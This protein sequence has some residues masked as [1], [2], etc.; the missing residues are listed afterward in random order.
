MNFIVD[1]SANLFGIAKFSDLKKIRDHLAQTKELMNNY[2]GGFHRY[3]QKV[4]FYQ[5]VQE[6]QVGNLKAW[7]YVNAEHIDII[8]NKLEEMQDSLSVELQLTRNMTREIKENINIENALMVWESYGI[9]TLEAAVQDGA[10]M[11]QALQQ[12]LAC[13]YK[14]TLYPQQCRRGYWEK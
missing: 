5:I 13:T 6:K 14:S 10:W 3:Q 11:F 12:L 8:H 4:H 1:I 9:K 2:I 7:H